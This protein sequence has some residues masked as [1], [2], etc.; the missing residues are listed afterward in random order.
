VGSFF[1]GRFLR[2]SEASLLATCQLLAIVDSMVG[3]GG[4][5]L[6]ET[7]CSS[8]PIFATRFASLWSQM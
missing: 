4:Q 6:I 5:L 3:F 1:F 8:Y 2:A 7:S